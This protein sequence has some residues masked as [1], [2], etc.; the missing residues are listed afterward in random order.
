MPS[1]EYDRKYGRGVR[2]V[3][4]LAEALAEADPA[5]PAKDPE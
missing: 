1:G 3:R 2:P 4:R 5:E